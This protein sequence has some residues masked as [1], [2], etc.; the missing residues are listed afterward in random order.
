MGEKDITF[1]DVI[2]I[3]GNIQVVW[4]WIGEGLEGDYNPDDHPS[5]KVLLF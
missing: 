4:E 1:E 2:L 3:Q 5:F